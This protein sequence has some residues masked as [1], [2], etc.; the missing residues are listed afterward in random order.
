MADEPNGAAGASVQTSAAPRLQII[1][2]F[3]RDMSFENFSAQ[4]G[5]TPEGKP[6]IRV[7]VNLDAQPRGT[8]IWDVATKI[9]IDSKLDGVPMFLMEL[10]FAG[11]FLVQNVPGEQLHPLLM[12]ECPRLMFPFV[13]RIVTDVTRDGGYP[14]LNLEIIDFLTLYRSEMAR[15]QAAGPETPP[16]G[17]A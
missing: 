1:N 16:A 3:I 9:K 15:R 13:R 6:E 4:K 7:Q 12:I 10:D 11:R 17:D 8:D 5:L 14:P 2:Q